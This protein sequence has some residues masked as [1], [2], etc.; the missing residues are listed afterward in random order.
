MTR[1][2]HAYLLSAA[3]LP[4][5]AA[6]TL[7]EERHQHSLRAG[8]HAPIG[9]MGDHAHDVGE[10]MLSYRFMSMAMDGNR[11]G[12]SRVEPTEIAGVT[13]NIFAD[14]PLQPNTLRVV[15]TDMTMDMHMLGAMYGVAPRITLM[16]MGSYVTKEMDHLTFSGMAPDGA[17]SGD[18]LL[19]TFTTTSEGFGDTRISALVR[20]PAL[21]RTQAL[22][23]IGVS[24]PTGST[25]QEDEILAP[26]GLRPTI[27]LPYPMQLGSGS[28]DPF[29]AYTITGNAGRFDY[30]VQ[31]SG[32]WRINDNNEGYRLG[33]EY[34]A[35]FWGAW[36][37]IDALSAS[38]RVAYLSEGDILRSDPDIVGPVQTANPDFQ[39]GD[40]VD[41]GVGLNAMVAG[42][43]LKGVRV[44]GEVL[45][46]V[47]QNLNGPQLETDLTFTL[48]LQYT[49]R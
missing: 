5:A 44:A 38:G 49:W 29:L 9:V 11:I 10:L 33:N 40:R 28:Y 19:G 1:S 46:P 21:G 47:Y 25:T 45:A 34:R 24:L 27:R 26:N 20:L 7:G 6:P 2:F 15:P 16:A 13:P 42:G 8:D 4:V 41:V 37:F 39:G 30:G 22:T 12:G 17:V 32:I 14:R 48:G 23:Q 35:T 43:P 36:S 3:L 18:D 31:A